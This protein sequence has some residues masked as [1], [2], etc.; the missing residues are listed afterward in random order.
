MRAATSCHRRAQSPSASFGFLCFGVSLLGLSSHSLAQTPYPSG[1]NIPGFPPPG[2]ANPATAPPAAPGAGGAP[3]TTPPA[4]TIIPSLEIGETYTDNVNLAPPGAE[5][6]DVI[7]TI[8]PGL[9]LVANTPRLTGSVLYDPQE[10]IFDRG[11]FPNT[12]QQRLLGTG[13]AEILPETLFLDANASIDQEFIR[14]TG[15]I[16]PTTLT[17]NGNLQTVEAATGSPYLLEHLGP[18]ANSETRYR[19]ATVSVSGNLIAPEQLNEAREILSSGDYFGPFSWALTGDFQK[20]D[21]LTGTSDPFGGTS[22]K[23]AL[24][25]ADFKYPIY[26]ALSAIGGAGYERIT[27]P[28]LI[29]EPHGLIWD[30]GLQYQPNPLFSASATYGRRFQQ[31]DIEVDATYHVSPALTGR[32]I[33]T[34][35]IQTGPSQIVNNLGLL[36]VS[37][38]GGLINSQTGSPFVPSIASPGVPS[39]AFGIASG[40]FLE[41]RFQADITVTRERD[42]YLFSAYDAKQ[43]GQN[44]LVFAPETIFGGSIGWTRQLWPDLASSIGASY[45]RARFEDGSSRVDN[46]YSVSLGLAYTLSRT[47]TANLSLSRFDTVSN[48]TVFRLI[49]DLVMATI[50]KQF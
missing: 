6:W 11:T 34:E 2:S 32:L 10:L 3:Q 25:R 9:Q 33:Y 20:I 37:S 4:W 7:T 35:A 40:A 28:T 36:T 24:A 12:L 44:S 19:F 22:S 50:R 16:G 49:N 46:S 5:V 27:D 23:D 8:T 17:T 39:S 30:A 14:N 18:Y 42:S 43:S 41:K 1:P 47:T 45:Y 13:R 38:S 29:I 15:P 26:G 48:F 31:S 21:R